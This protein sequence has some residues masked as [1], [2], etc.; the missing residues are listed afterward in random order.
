MLLAQT[1]PPA[2]PAAAAAQLRESFEMAVPTVPAPVRR[3]GQQ[4]LAY[5]LH[6]T[7]FSA[8]TLVLRAVRV[9]SAGGVVLQ[10]LDGARLA[11]CARVV[12]AALATPQ[13]PS[14]AVAPGARALVY[15]D[16]P[17]GSGETPPQVLHAVDYSVA[18]TRPKLTVTGARVAVGPAAALLL[19]PPVRGGPWAAVYHPEWPRGHRRVVY[20]ADGKACI[21][22]RFAI[23]WVKVDA[24][25][26][27]ATRNANRVAAALGYGADVL[28][29]ADATVYATRDDAVE[30]PT[31][32]ENPKHPLGEG[33]GNYVIL[34][35]ADGRY[36][37][38]EHLR[39]GSL[40]VKPGSQVRRGQ[41]L[42]ALGF[43]GDSTGPHLHFHVAD[44][45][46]LLGAEGSSYAFAQFTLL[47]QYTDITKMGS[48]KW[49]ERDTNLEALRNAELPGPNAVVSFSP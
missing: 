49:A 5:E 2:V 38:Y 42:A 44:G 40:R 48:A 11:G 20:T 13:R 28:A 46:S 30:S 34:Q 22:G 9:M 19:G 21:P 15:L 47:G 16:V 32:A 14:I 37:F 27:T 39:P 7:N 4:Y 31:I 24:R 36:A 18:G 43:T 26:R 6:L 10:H 23:D 45:S 41:V 8:D 3:E 12:R 1:V 35:L 33:A 17:Y 25:G 29:V